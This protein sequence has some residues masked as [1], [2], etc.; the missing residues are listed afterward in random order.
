MTTRPI[1]TLTTDFG[2]ED[3]YVGAIKG[4]LLSFLPDAQIIDISHAIAPQDI[5]AAADI[6]ERSCAFFPDNTVHLAVVDP[7]VGSARPLLALKTA[8]HIFVGPDNGLFSS[9]LRTEPVRIHRIANDSLFLSPVSPTFQGR[10]VMAPVAAR[11]AGGMD[12]GK[13]GPAVAVDSCRLLQKGSPESVGSQMIGE[14]V[15]HD[16]FGNLRTNIS[17]EEIKRFAGTGRIVV[18]IGDSRIEG[19]RSTYSDTAEGE[20]IALVDSH[21][22]VE[23][24]V[25]GGSA[26]QTLNARLGDR[27]VINRQER[28]ETDTP[29]TAS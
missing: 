26:W 18:R 22:R 4:V 28:G 5:G 25:A 19:L 10:D 17:A 14:I 27:I 16:H 29:G 3:E 9:F 24:A 21:N 13:A 8:R 12:I 2:L 6:L 23:I 7:G 20:L 11:L 1:I 15:S